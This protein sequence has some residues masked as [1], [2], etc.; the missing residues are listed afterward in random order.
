[1]VADDGRGR[2]D[3]PRPSALWERPAAPREG[4]S[5]RKVENVERGR[6]TDWQWRFDGWSRRARV[7]ALLLL[8]AIA[9]WGVVAS[10]GTADRVDGP[11]GKSDVDFYALVVDQMREGQGYY[12][13]IDAEQAAFGFPTKPFV[14]VREPTLAWVLATFPD[15][16]TTVLF[17]GLG[18]VAMALALRTFDL[19]ERRRSMWISLVLLSAC[20]LV[21]YGGDDPK[22]FHEVWAALLVFVG[23]L[24]VRLGRGR[25]SM[26]VLL[27][28]GL[29]RELVAPLMPIMAVLAW[30]AGRRREAVEW[31]AVTLAFTAFYGWHV[32]RVEHDVTSSSVD[33]PGWI[34][35][36]GWPGAV[37]AFASSSILLVA[38]LAVAS[39]VLALGVFGWVMREG[40]VF[41]PIAAAVVFYS[42][43]LSIG[44]RD[45]T[46]YWG[47]FVGGLI[48]VGVPIGVSAVVAMARPGAVPDDPTVAGT[49]G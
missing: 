46:W 7:A 41:E 11:E 2:T 23:L 5:A 3:R 25:P 36:R 13:V 27:A 38:P 9:L 12:D 15:V 30:R 45:D 21:I 16:V 32:W 20:V 33:S 43:L 42:V 48:V 6:D 10:S 17:A 39:I 40:P 28:A 31:L 49:S 22:N 1:M 19:T 29:V 14:T 4:A 35:L 44:G 37:D 47:Y 18:V 24:A 8:A 26:V 34:T